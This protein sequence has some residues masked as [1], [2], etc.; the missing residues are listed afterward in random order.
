MIDGCE[1]VLCN[2]VALEVAKAQ[3]EFV[4][5]R[6]MLLAAKMPDWT[7]G[8]HRGAF[9]NEGNQA[10]SKLRNNDAIWLAV[11]LTS[12]RLSAVVR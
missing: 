9:D 8:R 5:P 10:L 6:L 11:W 2:Q 4:Q 3:L 7:S 12:K 1:D